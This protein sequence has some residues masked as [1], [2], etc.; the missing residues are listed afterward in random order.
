MAT[1]KY[2]KYFVTADK[3]GLKLPSYRHTFDF[4]H[5]ATHLDADVVPDCRFYNESMW[6]VP[7]DT[8]AGGKVL[9]DAHTHDWGQLMGFYVYNYDD[10]HNLGCEIEFTIDGEKHVIA[11]SFTAFIPAGI[12]HGPLIVRNVTLPLFHFSSGDTDYYT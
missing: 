2:E 6:I 10:I 5:R 7:G 1:R 8:A 11:E 12:P 9:I 4:I 3:P